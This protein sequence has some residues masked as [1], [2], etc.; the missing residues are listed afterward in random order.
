ME[1]EMHEYEHLNQFE[2]FETE[3]MT[4]HTASHKSIISIMTKGGD[5]H[6][7]KKEA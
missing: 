3:T 5:F 7:H 4:R 2:T 6:T 1:V